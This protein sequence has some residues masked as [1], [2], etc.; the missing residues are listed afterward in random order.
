M[1]FS[2][3]EHWDLQVEWEEYLQCS[4]ICERILFE[5]MCVYIY[6]CIF[7]YLCMIFLNYMVYLFLSTSKML[8]SID[9]TMFGSPGQEIGP[10]SHEDL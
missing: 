5:N 8:A 4:R 10:T 7:I 1:V 6:I 3:Q 9:F 2:L